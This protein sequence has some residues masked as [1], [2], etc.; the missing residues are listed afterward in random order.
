MD[1]LIVVAGAGGFVGRA[2]LEYLLDKGHKRIR[3]VTSPANKFV[4]PTIPTLAL[5]LRDYNN[6]H[7]AIDGA[8]WII[9]LAAKAGG[10]GFLGSNKSNCIQASLINTNL[11]RAAA[12]QDL[13]GYFY[14]SSACVYSSS[15]TPI[16]EDDMLH[17]SPGY[18]QDKVFGEWTCQAFAEDYDIPVRI[19]R[20]TGIYGPGD[21]K[22]GKDHVH[23]ALCKKFIHALRTG[24][25]E[26][27]IW[28]DGQQTRDFLYIDDC[29]ESIY[30]ML[31]SNWNSSPVNIAHSDIVT[32]ENMV[33][34]LEDIAS[35]P[36]KRKYDLHAP[37]G[38]RN[39]V[40]DTSR[41]VHVL[42][43]WRPKIDL[44]T[45]LTRLYKSLL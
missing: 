33:T 15:D 44:V 42:T 5:D 19:A 30:R 16:K 13:R 6:C 4:H 36:V 41:M 38:C 20:F 23:A 11:L 45:G 10:I 3:A 29:V 7:M 28:G 18:G 35:M 9:N 39:R 17:P 34:L 2:M 31:N 14:A 37:Q 43:G 40:L 25:H 22:P 27:E 12:D 32:V 1:D 24:N 8:H 26:I 21:N